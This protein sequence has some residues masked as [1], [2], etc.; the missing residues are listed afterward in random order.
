MK[1]TLS[2][3]FEVFL[4]NG[5]CLACVYQVMDACGKLGVAGV[6]KNSKLLFNL[7]LFSVFNS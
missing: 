1:K 2:I 7:P 5:P 4:R 6:F 3:L